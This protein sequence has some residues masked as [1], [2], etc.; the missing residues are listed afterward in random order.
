M[1]VMM[2]R[3]ICPKCGADLAHIDHCDCEEDPYNDLDL[4]DNGEAPFQL[5][6]R[7]DEQWTK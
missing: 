4:S 2:P 3:E 6:C 5:P 1:S 7:D